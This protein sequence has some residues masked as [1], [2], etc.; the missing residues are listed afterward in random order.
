M[1]EFSRLKNRMTARPDAL[2]SKVLRGPGLTRSSVSRNFA[3]SRQV[4]AGIACDRLCA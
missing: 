4:I 1:I 3:S 2:P